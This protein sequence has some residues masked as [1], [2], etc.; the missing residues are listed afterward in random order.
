M[1]EL[2]HTYHLP[3]REAFFALRPL[4]S[5][6]GGVSVS[7]A[8]AA[9]GR[10]DIPSILS[11]EIEEVL[12]ATCRGLLPAET[13]DSISPCL[14]ATFWALSTYDICVPSATYAAVAK[15]T[16]S[17]MDEITKIL[18]KKIDS[19]KKTIENQPVD[20]KKK[21]KEKER[22]EKMLPLLALEEEHQVLLLFTSSL[23]YN[24]L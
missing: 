18:D 5:T 15:D 12:Q 2:C 4:L 20:P 16:K 17:S 8:T 10:V 21:S 9:S 6:H 3:P 23:I 1:H 24:Q 19:K 7:Q 11:D 13:W 22:L 14:Y